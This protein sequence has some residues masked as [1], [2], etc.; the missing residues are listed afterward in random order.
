ML[1]WAFCCPGVDVS[2]YRSSSHDSLSARL[3][4]V[5]I[6]SALGICAAIPL[7][8]ATIWLLLG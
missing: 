5:A 2:A 4:D 6:G 8:V 3:V 1:R 7:W